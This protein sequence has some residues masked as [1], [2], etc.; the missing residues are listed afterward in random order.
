LKGKR[1]NELFRR[2]GQDHVHLRAGLCQLGRWSA[3]L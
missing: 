1:R 3:A 2:A